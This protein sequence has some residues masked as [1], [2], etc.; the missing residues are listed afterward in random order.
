MHTGLNA[1]ALCTPSQCD[2]G[3]GSCQRK[4]PIGGAANEIPLKTR[5]SSLEPEMPETRPASTRTGSAIAAERIEAPAKNVPK[6][7][8][9]KRR[10]VSKYVRFGGSGSR[11]RN[12]LVGRLLTCAVQQIPCVPSGSGGQSKA[13]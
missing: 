12:V 5:T 6:T 13:G 2:G 4:S 1:S 8:E 11:M 7:R 10:M 9:N 3:R